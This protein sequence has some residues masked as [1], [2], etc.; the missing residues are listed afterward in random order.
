MVDHKTIQFELVKLVN[1]DR[2]LR[3][4]D[5]PTGLSLEK[6][7]GQSEPVVVQRDRLAQVFEAAL[8][9]AKMIGA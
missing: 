9:R 8:A 3:L 2:I 6:R 4:T 5:Q 1:G 7:L